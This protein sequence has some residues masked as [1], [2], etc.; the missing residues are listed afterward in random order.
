[1]V[2]EGKSSE[3][4]ESDLRGLIENKVPEGKTLEYKSKLPGNSD[5]DKKEFL[6]DVSSLANA[7]GGYLLYGIS[8]TS[9]IPIDILGC[10]VRD[11]DAVVRRLDNMVRDGIEPRLPMVSIDTIKLATGNL[12]IVIEVGSSWAG[13]HM[14]VFQNHGR[15]YSR[16]SAGKYQLDASELRLAFAASE[17]ARERVQSFRLGRLSKVIAGETPVKLCS[18]R[19]LILHL[20][21]LGS[22]TGFARYDTAV[23]EQKRGE[24]RPLY[25]AGWSHRHNFDGFVTFVAAEDGATH[26][27]LQVFRDG[28]IEAVESGMIEP[29]DERLEIPSL[30]YEQEL[31]EA[32]P[33]LLSTQKGLGAGV[34][35]VAMLSLVGVKGYRMAVDPRR[36]FVRDQPCIDRDVL[37][38]QPLLLD[39]F[40]VDPASALRPAFDEVWN[41][42]GWP[43]SLNYDES[44]VWRPDT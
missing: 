13:P 30:K 42:A 35:I 43:R 38:V 5:G 28:A 14:V 39:S 9:G 32:L 33:R 34:P 36:R 4:R 24:L 19:A 25:A 37:A 11:G 18:Q 3:I 7:S 40:E 16:N 1:M 6:A 44:G 2:F 21:P 31:I 22:A 29:W 27:Y 41:A 23:L 8:E 12:V 17:S 26:S 15:F 10:P 20:F